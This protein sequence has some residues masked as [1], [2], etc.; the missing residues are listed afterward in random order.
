MHLRSLCAPLAC[1]ALLSG[2]N[3]GPSDGPS[4][5]AVNGLVVGV[6]PVPGADVPGDAGLPATQ[7][8]AWVGA[9][10]GHG[11]FAMPEPKNIQV[12]CEQPAAACAPVDDGVRRSGSGRGLLAIVLDDSG[13]NDA[14]PS[15]CPG[16]PTDPDGL[17]VDAIRVLLHRVLG[18]APGWRIALFDF[19]NDTTGRNEAAAMLA[20]YSSYEADFSPALGKIEAGGGT[21]IYA[22]IVDV[23]PTLLGEQAAAKGDGGTLPPAR[24]LLMSDGQDTS[25][26]SLQDAIAAAQDAGV[27]IDTIGYGQRSDAGTVVLTAKASRDLRNIAYG[28]GGLC[29][30]VSTDELP[31]L[32]ARIGELYV[33]GYAERRFQMPAGAASVRGQ[34]GLGEA[35]ASFFFEDLR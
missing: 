22:S 8:T 2:C 34:V 7:F 10:D 25:S 31:A 5:P 20:G 12:T 13:S 18:R 6:E 1:A 16:C 24:I 29:S 35:T 9:L 15:D 17:R 28:T 26:D 3:C 23:L 11:G 4:N 30:I 21:Y 32:L 27:I 14:Y 19:G 33:A